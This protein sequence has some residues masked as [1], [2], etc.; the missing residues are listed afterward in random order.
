MA[1]ELDEVIGY[2]WP[3]FLK[4]MKTHW[5]QGQHLCLV[6]PTG[7]GKTTFVGGLCMLRRFVLIFDLKGGDR[8][9]DSLGW[10]RIT[11]WPLPHEYREMMQKGEPVRLIVGGRGRN[12][13]DKQRRR[14]LFVKVLT[15]VYEEGGWTVVIPDLSLLTDRR[16]GKAG[17]QVTELLLEARDALVSM[18]T[19]YQRPAGVPREA[20]DQSTY[21]ATSYTRD[22]DTVARLAEMFGRSRVAMRGSV[23]GLAEGEYTWLVVSRNPRE[24]IIV[25]Q[26]VKI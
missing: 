16:F 12:I 6:A 8:T 14:D 18:V 7:S 26:P 25:T 5:E 10:P 23:K 13:A 19:E 1:H 11:K 9:I 15:A 22:T 4:Y 24:P 2:P 21:L 20:A 3:E 17:D